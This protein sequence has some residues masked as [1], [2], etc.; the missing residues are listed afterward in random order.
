M[1]DKGRP[2]VREL[3]QHNAL[4]KRRLKRPNPRVSDETL[5]PDKRR[6]SDDHVVR[7]SR[8]HRHEIANR[9]IS[10][11]SK[12]PHCFAGDFGAVSV[13]FDALDGSVE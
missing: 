9:D 11:R 1:N 2:A 3:W 5:I 7:S 12:A 8:W 13:D 4:G 10:R 6:V